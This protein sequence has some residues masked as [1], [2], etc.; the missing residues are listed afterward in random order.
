[1][2]SN[3]QNMERHIKIVTIDEPS[4]ENPESSIR[5][6]DQVPNP[7]KGEGTPNQ[8]ACSMERV[9]E[10]AVSLRN[11][12]IP[13]ISLQSVTGSSPKPDRSN[14]DKTWGL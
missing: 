3:G 7:S 6:R 1:M 5:V 13:W 14:S 4:C 10:K 12:E 2:A 9:F 8:P 11:Q